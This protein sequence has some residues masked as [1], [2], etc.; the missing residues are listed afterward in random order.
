MSIEKVVTLLGVL[1]ALLMLLQGYDWW[2]K[3]QAK[4]SVDV[5]SS[6]V[7]LLKPYQEEVD[8]LRGSLVTANSQI[9]ELTRELNTAQSKADDLN[10]QL[11]DAQAE[12]GFLR[13]QV[14]IMS[15]QLG[16]DTK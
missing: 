5:V 6:A 7:H 9:I 3:R 12:L 11:V 14:K 10:N 8:R 13:S 15:I 4:S 1:T 2:K 16:K